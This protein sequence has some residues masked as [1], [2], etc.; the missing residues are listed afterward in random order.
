MKYVI[1]ITIA[2]T[3]PIGAVI[4]YFLRQ[5]IEDKII[6]KRDRD[7]RYALAFNEFSKDFTVALHR[8]DKAEER[9]DEIIRDEFP[10]HKDAFFKFEHMMRGS[11]DEIR[12]KQKWK[13]YD[14][15]QER[16][17]KYVWSGAPASDFPELVASDGYRAKDFNQILKKL[18][19]ELI[20]IARP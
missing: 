12:F 11:K 13:E 14:A 1:E 7:N 17:Y 18:I 4:G 15:K 6:R 9:A 3:L 5:C 19:E 8:L 16:I 20:N 10:R 2:I